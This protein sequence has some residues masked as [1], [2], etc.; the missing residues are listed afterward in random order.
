MPLVSA[1]L[2]ALLA[3]LGVAQT[4]QIP[5]SHD[6][7]APPV[8]TLVALALER[9]P[10]LAAMRARLAAAE[11]MIAPAGT[12]ANPM[13][14]IMVQEA[15]FPHYTVG[16]MEMS[17]IG[18]E[19]R[20]ALPYPGKRAARRASARATATIRS[21]ELDDL[22]RRLV[23]E[24]RTLYANLYALDQERATLI[25]AR[26]LLEMLAATAASRYSVGNAEQEA[27]VKAQLEVTRL[28][29]RSDDL[30]ARRA[31]LVAA[32]ERLL[33][34]PGATPLGVVT[35]LP[36]VET[37]PEPWVESVLAAA[38]EIA[39]RRAALAAAERRLE[40][41]RLDLKPDFSTGAAVGLR[42]SLDPVVTLRFGVELPIWRKEKQRPLIRAA[43]HE[44]EMAR[45]ELADAEAT[46][47]EETARLHAEWQR[48]NTQIVRYREAVLPQ[49]SAAVDAARA[50][51]LAGRGDF[52][53]VI[54]DFRMWLEARSELGRREADRY[55]VWAELTSLLDAAPVQPAPAPGNRGVQ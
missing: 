10:A 11:E 47:R 35:R 13:V 23:A 6:A 50:S 52:S 44:V 24:V 5:P 31:T 9:A 25:A 42:G 19:V 1:L 20:Q 34:R 15:S 27:V 32:L 48:A 55:M 12:L 37:P 4:P 7:P 45:A 14:E 36:A 53:T 33:D 22:R 49:S 21:S 29:E 3:S 39:V 54:E 30:I 18:P 8:E 43:E 51:Y 17:M 28:D 46:A 38:G 40:L 2:V 26:Q 16:E 41:G